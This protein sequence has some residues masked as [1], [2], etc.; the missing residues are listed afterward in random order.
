MYQQAYHGLN[1]LVTI[2]IGISIERKE[3][4]QGQQYVPVF[5]RK[6]ADIFVVGRAITGCKTYVEMLNKLR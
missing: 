2:V 1:N 6:F 4:N 3:D 5:E